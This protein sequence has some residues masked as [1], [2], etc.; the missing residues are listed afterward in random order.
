LIGPKGSTQKQL[1]ERTGTKILIRGRGSQKE[2][3][4]SSPDDDED[5]HVSIEGTDDA[6]N[7]A[8]K[9]IE[10]ILYNPQEAMRLKDEQLR[11][12]GATGPIHTS[13]AYTNNSGEY[14]EE[15]KVPNPMVGLIIGRGGENIHKLQGQT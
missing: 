9:E 6:I 1:Q 13:S 5:L 11:S 7:A 3:Q 12:L 15:L 8:A 2:G 14:Q 10:E 4:P